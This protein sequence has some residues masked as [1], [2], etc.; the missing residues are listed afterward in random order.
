MCF[1]PLID[2]TS[3]TDRPKREAC[4]ELVLPLLEPLNSIDRTSVG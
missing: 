2:I 4:E 3:G 1:P